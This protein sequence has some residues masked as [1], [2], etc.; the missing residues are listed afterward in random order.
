MPNSIPCCR[1]CWIRR[2][3]GNCKVTY[4]DTLLG[5]TKAKKRIKK[6]L[7]ITEN[8]R[9]LKFEDHGFEEE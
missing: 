2:S 5:I 8:C 9:T 7:G 4:G 3:R 1:R 6:E